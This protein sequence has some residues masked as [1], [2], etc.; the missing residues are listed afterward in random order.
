MPC[1]PTRKRMTPRTQ[2]VRVRAWA[3]LLVVSLAW[4]L[5]PTM[6]GAAPPVDPPSAV[7]HLFNGGF[8]PGA[9][10]TSSQPDLIRWQSTAFTAPFDLPLRAVTAIHFPVPAE[11]PRP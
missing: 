10:I 3:W 6:A 9:L 2:A 1:T 7:L 4:P 8:V 5:T 11:L